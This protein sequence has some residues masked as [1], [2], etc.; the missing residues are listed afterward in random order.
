MCNISVIIPFYKGNKYLTGLKQSLENACISYEG[1]VEV[2]MVNDSPNEKIEKTL[3]QSEKYDLVIVEHDVNYGIHKARVTGIGKAKG[4]Y[5]LLLDQDDK[6]KSE[7]FKEMSVPL[8]NN[9]S[10]AFAYA[11]GLFEDS[12]GKSKLI[13]NSYGKVYGA[14]NYH[15]YLKVGNLLA[16]PGQCLIRKSAIP[17]EWTEHIMWSNCADDFLL[18]IL[19]LRNQKA[20]YVNK[21]L[22]EH[23]TTGENTSGNKLVGYASDLEVCGILDTLDLLPIEELNKFKKRCVSNYNKAKGCDYRY[24]EWLLSRQTENFERMK[25]KII[26]VLYMILGKKICN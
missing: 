1:K 15:T 11:N 17:K 23:I 26:G 20:E 24:Q 3:I 25:M 10:I 2:I 16:S 19:I 21:L 7:F 9:K 12:N 13:L 8:N 4:E 5:I 14:E 6:I 18:W 22:Y